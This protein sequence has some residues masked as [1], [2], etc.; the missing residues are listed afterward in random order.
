MIVI[1]LYVLQT[2]S[3]VSNYTKSYPSKN[4]ASTSPHILTHTDQCSCASQY[5]NK[6]YTCYCM[7]SCCQIWCQGPELLISS[8]DNLILCV[9]PRKILGGTK[10]LFSLNSYSKLQNS[11]NSRRDI[12]R[13]LFGLGFFAFPNSSWKTTPSVKKLLQKGHFK[14][15]LKGQKNEEF[16]ATKFFLNFQ[17]MDRQNLSLPISLQILSLSLFLLWNKIVWIHTFLRNGQT[18]CVLQCTFCLSIS[19]ECVWPLN[20]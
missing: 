8:C 13:T 12:T 2:D 1:F 7:S 3:P 15:Q 19:Q 9:N 20:P 18:E 16:A 5:L 4:L 6:V 14:G 10:L 17:L 11:N